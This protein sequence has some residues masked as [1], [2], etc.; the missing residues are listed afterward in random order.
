MLPKELLDTYKSGG[1][2]Y[3]KFAWTDSD[4]MLANKV[5]KIYK[6]CIGKTYNYI[7]NKLRKLENADNYK[8]VRGFAKI[9]ERSCEFKMR[10][11]LD[12][13]AVRKFLFERGYVTTISERRKIIREAAEYFGV[14]DEEIEKAIFADREEEK[15]LV[16]MPDITSE[17]L[18][19]R[20]NLSLLQT[21]VFN[22]LRMTFWI[23]SNHKE[24][25][26]AIKW[27][28]LMYELYEDE[29][30]RLLT[31]I[32][33]A[34]SIF[35]MTKKYGTSMAKLIP[36]IIKAKEW[37]IRCEIVD[38]H[39]K[40]IYFFEISS[41]KRDLFP[42]YEE[43][44][45]FDSSLEEEFYRRMKNLG[46]EVIKDPEIIKSENRAYIP[47][48]LIKKDDK[49][50]YVEI[51]GFW[52][53]EYIKRKLEK[54]KAANIP[55]LLIAREDLALDKLKNVDVVVIKKNKIPYAEVLRKI[56]ELIS[57]S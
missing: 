29:N 51:V 55:L 57:R 38:E 32:T 3:P 27:L 28:G 9:I 21:L 40:K 45:E 49:K 47:D 2:I 52:T 12:P 30:G 15:V 8:K 39:E 42:Q 25:F 10:T 56:R 26:R 23:S 46:F 34:A 37:W 53:E 17:D 13:F 16:N 20:Y 31:D 4:L 33:G 19:K 44:I 43:K 22:C 54:I 6:E 50:V 36:S 5:I 24:V 35:K 7:L 1:K 18:V 14:S 11:N 48:F 41:K